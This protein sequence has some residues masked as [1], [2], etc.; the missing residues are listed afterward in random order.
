MSRPLA[1]LLVVA[2]AVP[3][4]AEE[5]P[6]EA[7]AAPLFDRVTDV[8]AKRFHDKGFRE[9]QL[10]LLIERFAPLAAK[11]ETL[12]QQRAVTHALLAEIPASHL[13]LLSKE[14][15]DRAMRELRGRPGPTFG[16]ELIAYDGKYFA[17]NVLEGGPAGKAGLLRGD[18]IVSI[19]GVPVEASARL[20]WR[21]DDAYLPDPPVH[22]IMGELDE[23][24]ELRV[25]RRPRE[26][27][28]FPITCAEYCAMEASR[29]GTRV[30]EADGLRFG[31][32]H[33]RYIHMTGTRSLVEDALNGP[34]ADCD[35]FVLDLRGR[36]GNG[37]AIN[38][39]LGLF[40]GDEPVW[41]KP[42]VAI[43]NTLTRSAKEIIAQQLKD[44]ELARLV[45]EPTAG[46]VI[47]ATFANVGHD[48]VLMFP[49]FRLGSFTR[50][51]EGHPVEPH[52]LVKDSGPY[53]AGAE[54]LIDAAVV[55]AARMVRAA[56]AVKK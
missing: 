52:V 33:L 35:A 45:G 44:L 23:T 56:E 16:F 38:G 18:R 24:I 1:F 51:L 5:K 9:K 49:T 53:S 54:P 22:D 17:R 40:R 12:A 21:T 27:V 20:D 47:P 4:L 30:I 8:L 37:M 26:Y 19:D 34:L 15:M 42:V 41:D 39:L 48:T 31:Y 28:T 29:V 46:A 36:G 14:S 32:V 50:D 6:G 10:P 25:E 3:A 43:T 55:E 11:A 13:G 2:L 7:T